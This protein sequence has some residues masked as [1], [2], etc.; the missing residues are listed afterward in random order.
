MNGL[1]LNGFSQLQGAVGPF[2]DKRLS[3]VMVIR[4]YYAMSI[5]LMAPG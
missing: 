4:Q 3:P 2:D 1:A 5:E